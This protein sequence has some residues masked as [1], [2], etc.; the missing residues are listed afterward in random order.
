MYALF[1]ESRAAEEVRL[2]ANNHPEVDV[3]ELLARTYQRNKE[4]RLS[5]DGFTPKEGPYSEDQNKKFDDWWVKWCLQDDKH[6]SFDID[7]LFC[8]GE[9]VEG[10]DFW[11]GV[12]LRE[13]DW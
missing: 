1:L 13:D 11:E 9:T 7:K 3:E 2:Y 12:S 8:W 5:D 4:S 6:K 10:H